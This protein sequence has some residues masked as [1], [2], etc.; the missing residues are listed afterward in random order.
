MGWLSR[1]LSSSLVP[2]SRKEFVSM[3]RHRALASHPPRASRHPCNDIGTPNPMGFLQ[4]RLR[5]L[6]RMVWMRMIKADDIQSTAPSL[7]LD[8]NQ[9]LRR[10][11]VAI[12]RGVERVFSAGTTSIT[13]LPPLPCAPAGRRSTRSDTSLPHAGESRRIF[14]S[15]A[16]HCDPY[17]CQNRSLKYLSALSHNTVTITAFSSRR[18]LLCNSL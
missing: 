17:S 5:P 16:Q 6:R 1:R 18:T 8:T 14:M 10:N 3:A 11:V 4:V 7:L 2:A 12:M 9:F 15:H 13:V